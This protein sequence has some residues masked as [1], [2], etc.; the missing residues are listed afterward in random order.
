MCAADHACVYVVE[1][2]ASSEIREILGAGPTFF[3]FLL[4][5]ERICVFCVSG[6]YCVLYVL[7]GLAWAEGKGHGERSTHPNCFSGNIYHI[8]LLES[9]SQSTFGSNQQIILGINATH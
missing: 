1:K 9:S 5:V 2:E 6:V 4:F 8:M 3:F 7:V